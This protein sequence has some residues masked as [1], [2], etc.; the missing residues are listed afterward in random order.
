MEPLVIRNRKITAED[1]PVIQA[2]VKE[3]WNR[4]RTHISRKLCKHWNWVQP[5]GRLK[6]I[7]CRELLLTLHRKGLIDYPPP[8]YTPKMSAEPPLKFMLTRL[9]STVLW[10]SWVLSGWRWSGTQSMNPLTTAWWISFITWLFPDFRQSPQIHGICRG[11]AHSLH[12]L[13]DRLSGQCNPEKSLRVPLGYCHYWGIG[14]CCFRGG[15]AFAGHSSAP[16][17]TWHLYQ[18]ITDF[19]Q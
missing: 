7:A 8:Q 3:H 16:S 2:V 15:E 1:L 19:L 9:P 6:D 11:C 4:G 18:A 12:R 10:P 5:I 17:V 13:G 14:Y